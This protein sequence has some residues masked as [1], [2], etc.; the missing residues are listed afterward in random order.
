MKVTFF[1]GAGASAIFEFPTT[2]EFMDKANKVIGFDPYIDVREFITTKLDVVDIEEILFKLKAL[3]DFCIDSKDYDKIQ[4]WYF[5]QKHKTL[6][7]QENR[8][9]LLKDY[10][11]L[12][13]NRIEQTIDQIYSIVYDTY[14]DLEKARKSK[15]YT[16]IY[17]FFGPDISFFTTN[18]DLSIENNF[19]NKPNLRNLLYDGFENQPEGTDLEF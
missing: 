10:I 15:I 13:P 16:T 4:Y 8:S 3:K 2:K 14:W 5:L 12:L 1:T 9:V 6:I 11:N 19:W 18:Y 7:A 17:D